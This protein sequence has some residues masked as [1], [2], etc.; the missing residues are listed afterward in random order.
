MRLRWPSMRFQRSSHDFRDLIDEVPEVS[1]DLPDI[2]DDLPEVSRRP[3]GHLPMMSR[4]SSTR[5]WRSSN[6]LPEVIDRPSGVLR[7]SDRAATPLHISRS[8]SGSYP[9]TSK[10]PTS[11]GG[12]SDDAHGRSGRRGP[13]ETRHVECR[14]PP[15]PAWIARH[16]RGCGERCG[17]SSEG[18]AQ[19]AERVK[20]RADAGAD[21]RGP[22][23]FP[24]RPLRR[25]V[26][27][28]QPPAHARGGRDDRSDHR[29]LGG[30]IDG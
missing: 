10:A 18:E 28:D 5:S 11:R 27:V 1:N 19:V 3:P 13:S 17:L 16:P 4:T 6:D 9:V 20:P 29:L 7:S 14:Y 15:G 23:D 24:P 2:A 26:A 25:R 30:G 22:A 12:R 21:R 8:N